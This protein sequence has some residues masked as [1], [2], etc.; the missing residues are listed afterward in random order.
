M[1]RPSVAP[2]EREVIKS[3]SFSVSARVAMQLGRES[4]SN[5]IV[6]IVELIKNAYDADAENVTLHFSDLDSDRSTLVIDDDGHGMTEE[7][8]VDNWLVIGTDNKLRSG[9]SRRKRRALTGEKGLGRLGLDRLCRETAVQSFSEVEEA[10]IELRIDWRKYENAGQRLETIQHPISRLP[11]KQL[12]NPTTGKLFTKSH[13]TRLILSDLKDTWNE[14]AIE[15]LR[16]ELSLLISPFAGPADFSIQ[17][18]A[19]N[20]H[21]QI[22]S[23][24]ILDAAEWKLEASITDTGYVTY[25]MRGIGGE[26]FDFTASWR[27]AF[28]ERYEEAPSCGPLDF[29]MYFIPRRSTKGLGFNRSQIDTFM[30]A[31]QG[32]RIYRDGFRVMPY[33]SPTGEGDW[34]SLAFRRMQSPAGRS[35]SGW[36]VGYNQVVGA[37]F[38]T[39][40]KNEQLLD[41]T[42]R[43]GIVDGAAFSALCTF[44]KSAIEWFERNQVSAFQLQSKMSEF[45]QKAQEAKQATEDAQRATSDLEKLVSDAIGALEGS[46]ESVMAPNNNEVRLKVMHAVAAVRERVGRSLEAQDKMTIAHDEVEEQL[47]RD[48]DTLQNLASLGILAVAFGHETLA[49]INLLTGNTNLLK[50]KLTL[51]VL[52]GVDARTKDVIE[53]SLKDITI[54]SRRIGAYGNFMLRNMRRDKRKRT[55][56]NIDRVFKDVFKPFELEKTR[57]V[58]TIMDFPQVIPPILAFVVDW[59]SIIVNL[60]TNS[61]WALQSVQ[62]RTIRVRI[63]A[64]DNLLHIWFADN[65]HGISAGT[66]HHIFE[67]GFT[68]KRN[69]QGDKIGTGMG[70][71]I[72][73][74]LVESYDGKV[75]ASSPSDLGGAEFHIQVNI[76]KLAARGRKASG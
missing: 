63:R 52:H 21:H 33:G 22:D 50:S 20:M 72:V 16:K 17:L 62:E 15:N 47:E 14:R 57:N 27:S 4:I 75:C 8:L 11:S 66:I 40:D 35:T 51:S 55:K 1:M 73:K 43:E 5:S 3:A 67:P 76:P 18:Y 53:A 61:L 59:E 65:G 71:T 7:V 23:T 58:H 30:E 19:H 10:G 32:I 2:Q 13:G 36:R 24:E 39:R 44:A 12:Q 49:H 70:L 46:E 74:D 25:I 56:V 68:T 64:R 60:L 54:A 34:L 28:P 6:G 41:Q 29:I 45:S 26:E 38:I 69:E 42:N 37:V 48:I 9:F 31:N